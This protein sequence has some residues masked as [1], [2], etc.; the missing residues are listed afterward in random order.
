MKIKT[1]DKVKALAGKDR[2][3]TG[4]VLQ[5]FE[6]ENRVAVEDLNLL[7]KHQKPRKQGEAGQRI[8]FS[9]PM[10]VDN[11]ALVCPKCNKTTRVGY[12]ITRAKSKDK[13]N[14]TIKQLKNRVC[15]KCK[16]LI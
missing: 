16:E 6:K 1:G 2:G 11:V 4:K 13:E 12:K 14:N 9:A 5:V 8:Q 3:K 15:R 10:S 7:I